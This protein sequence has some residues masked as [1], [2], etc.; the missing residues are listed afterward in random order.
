M[1]LISRTQVY[2]IVARLHI[3]SSRPLFLVY[4]PYSAFRSLASSL[5]SLD[6]HDALR[7]PVLPRPTSSSTSRHPIPPS[8][9]ALQSYLRTLIISLS[10]PPASALSSLPL[11][12]ARTALEKFLLHE[13]EEV[14]R[15]EI[16]S[17]VSS[18]MAE[19]VAAEIVRQRWV[20]AGKRVKKLRTMWVLWKGALISGGTSFSLARGQELRKS[21]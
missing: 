13:P 20:G 4:R 18:S 6:P 14:L 10:A 2:T 3:T 16:E 8:R 9:P 21:R 17:W 15:G 1:K 5:T 12:E 19:D 7:L 11:I